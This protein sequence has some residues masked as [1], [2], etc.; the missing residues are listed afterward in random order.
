MLKLDVHEDEDQ[1]I[2]LCPLLFV[3]ASPLPPPPSL[4]P[5]PPPPPP[6]IIT[7]SLYATRW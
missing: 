3:Y 4:L 2:F 7:C 1:I 6:P 5:P